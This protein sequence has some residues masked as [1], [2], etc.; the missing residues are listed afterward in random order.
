[1]VRIL[2]SKE[3]SYKRRKVATKKTTKK[4][5]LK[6]VTGLE[7][8]S[9]KKIIKKIVSKK[10]IKTAKKA[11][12][13]TVRTKNKETG[14]GFMN[15]IAIAIVIAIIGLI[16]LLAERNG[17]SITTTKSVQAVQT[18]SYDCNADQNALTLL[19]EKNEVKTQDS[20]YGIFVDSINNQSNND[21]SFWIF[22]VNGQIANVGPDQYN[23]QTGDK[24]EWR[25]EKVF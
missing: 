11:I 12:S 18:V 8:K 4:E 3:I 17:T 10:T 14:I 7:P 20:S 25:F 1:M 21:D 6:K 16:A 5:D 15:I 2:D 19:K 24:I 23:C 9:D 13:S 22:Y